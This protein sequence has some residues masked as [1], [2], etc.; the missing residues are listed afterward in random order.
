MEAMIQKKPT[1]WLVHTDTGTHEF[2]TE[3]EAKE[4]A[5]HKPEKKEEAPKA[6]EE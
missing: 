1:H 3:K 6:E 2:A 5:G 4:F